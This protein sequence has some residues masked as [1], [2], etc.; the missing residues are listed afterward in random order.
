MASKKPSLSPEEIEDANE[1]TNAVGL[2]H[3]ALSYRHAADALGT[4]KL[5]ATHPEAP[6]EFLYYHS[7]ELFLKA[8]LR[9]AGLSVL[10]LKGLSHRTGK[11]ESEFLRHGGELMDEDRE[12]LELMEKTDVVAQSRYIRTGFFTK[13]TLEALAR[14]AKSLA[15]TTRSALKQ[16]GL[17]VR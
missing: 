14:T 15:D 3:Y 6:R 2:Y 11:L 9:N 7:I 5:R 8:Y 12:V 4:V 1:R 17:P 10:A 16:T 13:P